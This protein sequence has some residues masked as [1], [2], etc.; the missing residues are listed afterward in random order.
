[1]QAN[2][3]EERPLAGPGLLGPA[4]EPTTD[5]RR[6]QR[7]LNGWALPIRTKENHS[8]E[9]PRPVSL[10]QLR[11]HRADWGGCRRRRPIHGGHGRLV[12]R[13]L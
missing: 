13:V 9:S 6:Q 2:Q 8:A 10:H 4:R 1:M 3:L 11:S 12:K 7:F 5:V